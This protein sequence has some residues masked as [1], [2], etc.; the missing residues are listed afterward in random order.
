MQFCPRWL[1]ER[2]GTFPDRRPRKSSTPGDK[3]KNDVSI[4]V[5][6]RPKK[7]VEAKK[8]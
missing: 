8:K 1:S 5:V 4:Q 7:K 2:A 6:K 3:Q